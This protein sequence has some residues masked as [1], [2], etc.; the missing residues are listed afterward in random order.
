MQQVTALLDDSREVQCSFARQFSFLR[1]P[2]CVLGGGMCA[3]AVM[4]RT[5][6]LCNAFQAVLAACSCN[7][8]WD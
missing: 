1:I 8:L 4:S 2:A 6:S 5:A 7:R 3:A